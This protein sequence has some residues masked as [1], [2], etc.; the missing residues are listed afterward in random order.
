MWY[1]SWISLTLVCIAG[2]FTLSSCTPARSSAQVKGVGHAAL[3]QGRYTTVWAEPGVSSVLARGLVALA[4]RL[5]THI[6][7]DFGISP[8]R[9]RIDVYA[10]HDS[11]ARALWLTQR[12]RPQSSTDDTSSIV[13]STLLLGPLPRR[14]LQHNLA[15][16]YTEWVIDRVT[17]NVSDALPSNPWLYDGLAEYEAYRYEP[18]GMPCRVGRNPPFDVTTV[19]TARRWL[20]LRSGPTGSLMYCL[21][22]VKVR[23]FV[24]AL[25]WSWFEHALR[26]PGGWRMLPQRIRGALSREP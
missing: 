15:H 4:D 18:A 23:S 26:W 8:S 14:Y 11:F 20:A 16:V 9:L 21:A 24:S 7:H 17:G 22:Y 10:S 12:Q 3:L 19:H 5:P 13:R 1:R 2:C 25:G 6:G